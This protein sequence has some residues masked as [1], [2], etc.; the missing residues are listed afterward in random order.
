[1]NC[2]H[3]FNNGLK[4]LNE[5]YKHYD[6]C[7]IHYHKIKF[8]KHFLIQCGKNI[9]IDNFIEDKSPFLYIG[10]NNKYNKDFNYVHCILNGHKEI[11]LKYFPKFSNINIF[12]YYVSIYEN[13]LNENN[14]IIS[15]NAKKNNILNGFWKRSNKE[16]IFYLFY[17]NDG[18][19]IR[20]NEQEFKYIL[21]EIY[22]QSILKYSNYC[23]VKKLFKP[24][25]ITVYVNGKLADLDKLYLESFPE[26]F[27][28]LSCMLKEYFPWHKYPIK[29]ILI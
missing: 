10:L 13:E 1:M 8:Q 26:R 2:E 22:Y 6:Y 14:Q 15:L 3:I 23:F 5:K 25:D 24:D 17:D 16:P 18:N 11:N 7:L 12:L 19:E 9:E 29:N 21:C 27:Y 4:C 28:V 20:L